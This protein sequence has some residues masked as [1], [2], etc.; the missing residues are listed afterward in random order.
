[1]GGGGENAGVYW[2]IFFCQGLLLGLGGSCFFLH[3]SHVA[4]QVGCFEWGV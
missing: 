2:G 1:V 3:S 4:I